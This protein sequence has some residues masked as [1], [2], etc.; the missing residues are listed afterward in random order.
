MDTDI[1]SLNLLFE[2]LGLPSSD[3]EIASF[4]ASHRPLP[5]ELPLHQAAFWTESQSAFIKQA[6]DDDA[7][8]AE[9]VDELDALLRH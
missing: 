5:A 9:W 1:H 8:W 6:I 7:D 4:V 2:Q 3:S